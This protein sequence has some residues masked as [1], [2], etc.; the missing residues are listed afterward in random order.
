MNSGVNHRIKYLIVA[1]LQCVKII[2]AGP[3]KRFGY[4]VTLYLLLNEKSE[5]MVFTT[6]YQQEYQDVMQEKKYEDRLVN[7]I[8]VTLCLTILSY[9]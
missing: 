6:P 1:L 5:K 4:R 3:F 2:T 7:Y 9:R 8:V